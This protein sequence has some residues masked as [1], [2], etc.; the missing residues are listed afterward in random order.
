MIGKKSAVGDRPAVRR[1][2]AGVINWARMPYATRRILTEEDVASQNSTVRAYFFCSRPCRLADV[3]Q[4]LTIWHE[5]G[6][7][8]E[9]EEDEWE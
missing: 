8:A 9:P 5:D 4:F 6:S 7:T 1:K 3:R 2:D